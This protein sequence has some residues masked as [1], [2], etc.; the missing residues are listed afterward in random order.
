MESRL[1]NCVSALRVPPR[2]APPA[3]RTA[4]KTPCGDTAT[5]AGRAPTVIASTLL[6]AGSTRA[7]EPRS[8]VTQIDSPPAATPDGS[9][10]TGIVLVTDSVCGSTRDSVP[11]W[12]FATQTEPKSTATPV[13]PRPTLMGS[14]T[15]L[16]GS[17]LR[18]LPPDSLA[19]HTAPSP[20]ARATMPAPTASRG[21]SRPVRGSISEMVWSSRL[22]TQTEP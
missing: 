21:R 22:A 6:S 13:G 9:S 11:S 17:S 7:T 12:P 19:A 1:R 4:T 2:C 15:P 3:G 5:P 8:V 10:P 16:R 18:S 14:N 20:T